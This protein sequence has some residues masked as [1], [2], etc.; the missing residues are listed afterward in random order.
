MEDKQPVE[1]GTF[2][3]RFLRISVYIRWR[4]AIGLVFGN[5]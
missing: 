2:R 5:G 3:A 4:Y 1:N